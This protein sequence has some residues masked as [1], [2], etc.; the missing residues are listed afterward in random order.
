MKQR[1]IAMALALLLL[2]G[3]GA[4]TASAVGSFGGGVA[5]LAEE[6]GMI[7]GAVRGE[8]VRFSATDF[9][10]AMGLRR[11]EGITVA[12]LPEA[13][14]GVLYFA[15][16]PVAAGTTVPRA[17]LAS[18]SFVPKDGGVR[19]A[20]FTFTCA[21]YAGG[22]EV[23][24]VIRFAEKLN[25][26][27]TV[28]DVAASRAVSTY[29][30]LCAEGTLCATDPEGDALEYL[31]V[32]YP[33][34]GTLSVLDSAYGDFRYTPVAGYTGRDSFTFV[35][36]DVFGNYSAPAEVSVT[37][38]PRATLRYE[39][40]SGLAVSLP[41]IALGE[42]N[43]MVGTM[44]GDGM[45]FSPDE[46][47]DRGEFLVMAMKAAGV[48]PRRGLVHTVFDDDGKIPAGI[49]PYAATAQEAGYVHGTLSDEGLVFAAEETI[50]RGEAAVILARILK[51]KQ[52]TGATLSYGDEEM[53]SRVREATL[54]LSAAGIYP[55]TEDGLLATASPLT[56]AAAAEMLYATLLSRK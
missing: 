14:A 18:L 45:Y 15:D 50:S 23:D 6:T 3:A 44:V 9:K 47:L 51:V 43:I 56:R 27:P 16:Q 10:Q 38:E 17:S 7:K 8:T 52:P 42:E 22:A 5:V 40:L 29:R 24:C 33:A 55:R 34:H 32:S 37:V 36:R 49:R 53:P 28:T 12:T 31:I 13:E 20:A 30:D 2:T 35:V 48:A 21:E 11:F 25:K 1:L 19:E 26:A 39:D 54:A 4:V 41:A 46:T